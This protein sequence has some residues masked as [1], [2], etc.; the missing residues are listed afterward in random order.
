MVESCVIDANNLWET[1]IL[2]SDS[3]GNIWIWT[4]LESQTS[5]S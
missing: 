4:G 1:I 5:R 2:K 3:K